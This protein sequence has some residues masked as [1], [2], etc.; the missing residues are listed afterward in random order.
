MAVALTLGWV[1]AFSTAW[2]RLGM[3]LTGLLAALLGTGLW[4]AFDAAEVA[5]SARAINYLVLVAIALVLAVATTWKAGDA[6][7]G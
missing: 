4:W 6:E 3:I 1:V 5:V 2:R 7:D